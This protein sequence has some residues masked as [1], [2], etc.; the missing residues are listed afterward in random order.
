MSV[1]DNPG[2]ITATGGIWRCYREAQGRADS[3]TK[4]RKMAVLIENDFNALVK[5]ASN[6]DGGFVS[7][8]PELDVTFGGRMALNGQMPSS[9]A[10]NQSGCVSAAFSWE[11]GEPAA[12]FFF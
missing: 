1:K 2:P 3:N 10:G 7:F 6:I 5:C 12:A 8:S 11:S 9:V 4:D